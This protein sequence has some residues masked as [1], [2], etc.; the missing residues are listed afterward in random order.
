MHAEF[1]NREPHH[2]FEGDAP[3]RDVVHSLDMRRS[4][5]GIDMDV[6]KVGLSR[7]RRMPVEGNDFSA[8]V[9]VELIEISS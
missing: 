8:P 6:S 1:L 5:V 9:L 4:V 7:L 2:G 3:G